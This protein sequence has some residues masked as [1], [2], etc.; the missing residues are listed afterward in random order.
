MKAGHR[1][2]TLMMPA[3][4]L[5]EEAE[6]G[7]MKEVRM[8]SVMGMIDKDGERGFQEIVVRATKGTHGN[9]ISLSAG[10]D[11]L[12]AVRTEEIRDLMQWLLEVFP[13]A[14]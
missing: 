13:P 14:T 1:W 5:P 12:L 7:A 11:I 2:I 6:H 8:R 9:C 4:R 10:N 3:C